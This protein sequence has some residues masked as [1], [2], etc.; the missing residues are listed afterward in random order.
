MFLEIYFLI[1]LVGF[2]SSSVAE[3]KKLNPR[4]TL[5][6]EKF[7]KFMEDLKL[8]YPKYIGKHCCAIRHPSTVASCMLLLHSMCNMRG[9]TTW[10][11]SLHI[12]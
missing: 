3:E 11:P 4:L 6:R 8:D 12:R 2:T 1:L 5:S 7:V 10:W 9:I